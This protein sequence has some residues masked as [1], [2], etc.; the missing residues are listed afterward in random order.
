VPD[1]RH[2]GSGPDVPADRAKFGAAAVGAQSL[3][4]AVGTATTHE[5][6]LVEDTE[7]AFWASLEFRICREFAGFE[8]KQL[9]SNWCDGLVPDEY[10][11]QSE[12][13]SIRGTAYCGRSGQERWRFMLLIGNSVGS[14]ADIDWESLLPSAAVTGWLSPHL[15]ERQLILDP[16]SSRPD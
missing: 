6:V 15:S 7:K 4:L 16:L 12:Q 11:L 13:P 14:A 9:R 8:D 3:N 1:Q 2:T 5:E 10:D